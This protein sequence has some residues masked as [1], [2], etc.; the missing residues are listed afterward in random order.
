MSKKSIL[1]KRGQDCKYTEDCIWGA[2]GWCDRP[3][4]GKCVLEELE[5][6]KEKEESLC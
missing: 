4:E 5:K 3:K 6:Q 2:D 1:P